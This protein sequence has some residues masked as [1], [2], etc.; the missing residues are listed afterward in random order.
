[1]YLYSPFLDHWLGNEAY[2]RPHN[3]VHISE[4]LISQFSPHHDHRDTDSSVNS[5]DQDQHEEGIL[6]LLDIDALL[7]LLLASDIAPSA[8]PVQHP[9][10]ALELAPD[11]RSVSS[12]HLASLDP[13]P[14][15]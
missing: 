11:S 12:I 8:E 1:M 7:A 3:H 15:I 4:D 5:V 6:C 2:S 13:P 9:P 10:L 14:N